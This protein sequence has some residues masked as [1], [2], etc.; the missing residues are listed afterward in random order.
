MCSSP[1]LCNPAPFLCNPAPFLWNFEDFWCLNIRC[2]R[3]DFQRSFVLEE[4]AANDVRLPLY[5]Q[6]TRMYNVLSPMY[7]GENMFLLPE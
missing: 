6:N 3:R 4:L 5:G 2:K 1:F 7:E